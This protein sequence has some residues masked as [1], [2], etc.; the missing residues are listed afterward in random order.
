MDEKRNPLTEEELKLIEETERFMEEVYSDPEVANA[1]LPQDMLENIF[2]E[3]HAREA[4]QKK[5]EN[6]EMEVLTEEDRELIYLGKRYKSQ[7]KARKYLVLAAALVLALTLGITSLGGPERVFRQMTRMI[8]GEHHIYVS[9]EDEGA[10]PPLGMEEEELYQRIEEEFDFVPVRIRELSKDMGFMEGEVYDNIQG[11]VLLYGKNQETKISY[12]IRPNYTEGSWGIG[13]DDEFLREYEMQLE[14]ANIQ[15]RQYRVEDGEER[16]M[17]TFEY[18]DV[19]YM[20]LIM[21]TNQEEAEMIV[22][23]LL[24]L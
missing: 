1:P 14:S 6:Q 11:A 12:T 13:L 23:N 3:I 10:A 24:F 19:G 8:G 4:E 22:K 7:R 21:D 2:R 5:Q 15:L 17:A 16:W 20:L 18:Q 9:S